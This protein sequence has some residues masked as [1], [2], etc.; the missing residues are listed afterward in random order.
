MID[1]DVAFFG[2]ASADDSRACGNAKLVHTVS[3][4]RPNLSGLF[5]GSQTLQRSPSVRS[6]AR[7]AFRF[8]SLETS[9]SRPIRAACSK[10][11]RQM[12]FAGAES[13]VSLSR[14]LL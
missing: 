4:F 8:S 5:V 2:D 14:S 6:R 12:R 9:D 11:T 1:D 10:M 7:S 3:D 13:R